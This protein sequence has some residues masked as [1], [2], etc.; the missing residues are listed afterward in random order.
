MSVLLGTFIIGHFCPTWDRYF[1]SIGM[2]LF[3]IIFCRWKRFLNILFFGEHRE[4]KFVTFEKINSFKRGGVR[5]AF[6]GIVTIMTWVK[7]WGAQVG[8]LFFQK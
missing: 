4:K 8:D 7:C 2:E 1:M 5:T 6:E 3:G